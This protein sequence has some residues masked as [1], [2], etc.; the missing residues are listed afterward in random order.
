MIYQRLRNLL[1]IRTKNISKRIQRALQELAENLAEE[2]AQR[3]P[4]PIPVRNGGRRLGQ[5]QLGFKRNHD[6]F[7]GGI[8]FLGFKRCF[9]TFTG[10]F[11]ARRG[12]GTFNGFYCPRGNHHQFNPCRNNFNIFKTRWFAKFYNTKNGGSKILKAF[13]QGFMFHNFSSAF[14]NG[15]RL[16][17]CKQNINLTYRTVLYNLTQQLSFTAGSTNLGIRSELLKRDLAKKNPSIRL[18]L[19]LSPKHHTLTLKLARTDSTASQQERQQSNQVHN[20]SYIEF[21]VNFNLNIPQETIL[22]EEVLDEMLY[23]VQAF[24]KQLREFKGDLQNLFEL[25][26]LPIK[27]IKEK[28][29][30]RVYF[31]NCDPQKLESLCR[32]KNIAGGVI[33]EDFSLVQDEPEVFRSRK[34][35]VS[36]PYSSDSMSHASSYDVNHNDILS[37]Y[38]NTNGSVSSY[39]DTEDIL[40]DSLVEPLSNEDIVRLDGFYQEQQE[41]VMLFGSYDESYWVSSS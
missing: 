15:Y 2:G 13:N 26:E 18:N 34:S 17:L 12:F 9:G 22:S 25:G 14:Q 30:L 7:H 21:P 40:S 41:P 24:E 39:D 19:S 8:D 38:Y 23:N 27:Y 37:S 4:I 35:S 33:Y 20:G 10:R 31:P 5:N 16:N 11:A 32:E 6:A 3:Q 36:V 29:A 28:S 1:A